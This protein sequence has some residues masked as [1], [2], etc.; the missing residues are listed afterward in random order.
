MK[1]IIVTGGNLFQLASQYLGDGTQWWRIAM[2]NG[3]TDPF[4]SGTVALIIPDVQA[5]V[6]SAPNTAYTPGPGGAYSGM[7]G[8]NYSSTS[9]G[10]Y[11]Y[12]SSGGYSSVP[13]GGYSSVSSGGYGSASVTTSVT[14][15]GYTSGT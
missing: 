8:G 7:S 12:T 4:L 9:S 2:L 3:L 1:N 10:G 5:S 15:S 13:N 6:P 14:G 11:G